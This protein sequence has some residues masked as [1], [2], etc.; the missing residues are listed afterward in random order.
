[1][2][3]FTEDDKVDLCYAVDDLCN[4]I[5]HLFEKQLIPYSIVEWAYNSKCNAQTTVQ[6][7]KDKQVKV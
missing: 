7:C 2:K 1:M 4:L 6:Q 5:D 3:N